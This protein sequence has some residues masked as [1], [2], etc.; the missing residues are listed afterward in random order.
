MNNTFF[1]RAGLVLALIQSID[2]L[3]L[4]K[5]DADAAVENNLAQHIEDSYDVI[6]DNYFG[7]P[8]MVGDPCFGFDETTGQEFGACAKG[9]MCKKQAH[10]EV[11]IPGRGNICVQPLAQKGDKCKGFNEATGE[12]YPDCDGGLKCIDTGLASIGGGSSNICVAESQIDEQCEGSNPN[13]G[14]FF[15]ACAKGLQCMKTSHV[16]MMNVKKICV[17]PA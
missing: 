2:A 15:G 13:T 7:G 14:E 16:K 1:K 3:A 4:H 12:S 17:V 5:H 6:N 11:S 8:G 9:L 10:G